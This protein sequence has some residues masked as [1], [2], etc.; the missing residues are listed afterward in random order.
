ML[1]APNPVL[2]SQSLEAQALQSTRGP[3]RMIFLGRGDRGSK[4]GYVA[5]LSIEA[6]FMLRK[7]LCSLGLAILYKL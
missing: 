5:L 6:G 4:T 7:L 1:R 2:A 3:S